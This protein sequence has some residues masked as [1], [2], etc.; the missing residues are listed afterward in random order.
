MSIPFSLHGLCTSGSRVVNQYRYRVMNPVLHITHHKVISQ[1]TLIF[2]R[3]YFKELEP[4]H[5]F[6]F[7]LILCLPDLKPGQILLQVMSALLVREQREIIT[8]LPPTTQYSQNGF[9]NCLQSP[10]FRMPHALGFISLHKKSTDWDCDIEEDPPSSILS[11]KFI[12][13]MGHWTCHS[14]PL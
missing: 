9:S 11:C 5:V 1:A 13:K 12:G 3:S 4:F 6:T 10:Y 14:Y 7:L 2:E 8:V